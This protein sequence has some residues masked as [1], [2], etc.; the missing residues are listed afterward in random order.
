MKVEIW[1]RKGLF[2]VKARLYYDK[3]SN[4]PLSEGWILWD[5]VKN[6]TRISKGYA[7]PDY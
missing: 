6:A 2:W 3:D 4:Q 1:D 5:T 7:S